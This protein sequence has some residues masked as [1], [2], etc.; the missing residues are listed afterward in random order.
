[1]PAQT[2]NVEKAIGYSFKNAELLE[3]A[4]MHPSHKLAR[5]GKTDFERLEFLGDSVL[6]VLVAELLFELFPDEREGDLAKRKSSLVSRDILAEIAVKINI[7]EA[8]R[9]S[10]RA[11]SKS[12]KA[13]QSVLENACEALIGAMYL[14]GGFEIAQKFVHSIWLPLAKEAASPPKDPKTTL[15]EWAQARGMPLPEYIELGRSGSD[16]SP[17]FAIEVRIPG[18]EPVRG[19]GN[20]KKSASADAAARMLSVI[21]DN[22]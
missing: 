10:S 20:N 9:F 22:K 5:K 16:H 6:G 12:G 18:K 1:M 21:N 11:G 2:S 13:Q 14:D 17:V 3:S 19:T 8:L 7:D 15:Q 4:L